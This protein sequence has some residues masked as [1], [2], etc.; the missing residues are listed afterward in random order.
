MAGRRAG[1]PGRARRRRR[2]GRWSDAAGRGDE[3][4]NLGTFARGLDLIGIPRKRT[5]PFGRELALSQ[6]IPAN[7][8]V[9]VVVAKSTVDTTGLERPI[10]SVLPDH[11]N[12]NDY[13]RN[14]FARLH[15]RPIEGEPL[16]FHMRM[17]FEGERWSASVFKEL[18]ETNGDLFPITRIQRSFVSLI[19][20]VED[21]GKLIA[22]LGFEVGVSALRR[23]RDAVVLRIE[24]AD[25]V[26]LK[27]IESE[28]FHIGVLR[29][30]GAYAALRRGGR[31]FRPDPP[32]PVDDAAIDVSFSAHLRSADNP[33]EISFEFAPDEL[34]RDRTSILIGRN[35]AG[36][37]QLLKAIVDGLH[38]DHPEGFLPPQFSPAF[39]P[40]RVL[41][42][43]SVPTDPFPRSLGAWHGIDY[44]Y[45]ALNASRE[46]GTDPLLSA[47]VNCKRTH[48]DERFGS[49]RRM[50]RLDVVKKALEQIGL[51]R[52]LYLPL[53]EIIEGDEL[54]GVLER[55]GQRFFHLDTSLNE[56]NRLKLGHRI[57]WHRTAVV[58]DDQLMPRDLSSGEYAMLRFAAQAAA[59]V[60]RGSLLLFDEPE[61]HLHPNFV[62]ELMEILDNL[63][64]STKSVAIIATHSAYVV[65]EAPRR[66]VNVLTL[67]N[68][69]IAVDTPRVQT[70][71]ASIDTISQF[72][73][74]DTNLSHQFQKTLERWADEIGR[75][76]GIDAVIERYGK[77][78]NPE[79]LSFIAKRLREAPPPPAG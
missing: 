15:I 44:E 27:L 36:K 56:L 64:Q 48:D 18:L 40:L 76:L 77:E 66:R 43:S 20:N 28:E 73:F 14:F 13:G 61:T 32:P 9:Q 21:Y 71:G 24:D 41:V 62:S 25:E 3:C 22:A 50:S 16:E 2:R 65:R 4:F 29:N 26:G 52:R 58:L 55:D 10:I 12:W 23:L 34:F 46:D 75:K 6:I 31:Y 68:R 54:P 53:R 11:D 7:V 33:Y 79:S 19:P 35:G 67:Q 57:D 78:L 47:L 70:F 69:E 45:F 60:E 49:D 51:W 59:A 42:F 74:G 5:S 1:R 17:M 37:T 38:R 72:V 39:R 8:D 30:D 63:L